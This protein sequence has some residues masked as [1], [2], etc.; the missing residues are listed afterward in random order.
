MKG[1]VFTEFLEM[2][3]ETF[4]AD[5]VDQIIEASALSSHGVYT[6]VGSYDHAELLQL[7]THLSE[8]TGMAVPD[9]IRAFGKH[10][11]GRFVQ[12][13]PHF[14]E[15][16]DS[17]FTFLPQVENYIHIEVKKL[18]PDAELPS[19]ACDASHPG[20]LVMTYK[21]SRP[22]AELAEGLILACIAHYGEDIAL[23]SEDLSGAQRTHVCFTLTQRC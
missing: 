13:Y 3:E 16:V 1:M 6:A 4:S 18:Y 8:I 5:V 22:F 10:L 9:L 2:V 14:F 19:F 20:Q 23:T 7:V 15:G 12:G 21:S 11:F 17:V